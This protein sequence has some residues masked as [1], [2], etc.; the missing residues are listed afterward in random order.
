LHSRIQSTVRPNLVLG[1]CCLSLLVVGMD[2]TIVNV[3][4]PAIRRDFHAEVSGLQ[5]LMDAYTLVVASLLMLGG[6]TADRLGRRRTF[7]AGMALF[8]FASLL[9]SLAPSIGLLI[10]F[11]ALQGVGAS[12]L[13]PVAM[14]IITNTFEEPKAR[15]K[16]IGVWGAVAGLSLAVGPLL[17][18]ALTQFV[19][20][21]SIFW[22]NLPIGI[23]A[24]VLA[25]R[26]VPESKAAKPR[27][28]DP[29]GQFL[30]FVGLASLI[31]AIIEGP[32]SGWNSGR[33]EVAF[34]VSAVAVVT[35]VFYERRCTEPLLDL[36]FFGSLPFSS[37]TLI[38]VCAFSAFAA[39][40]L[41]NALYLQQV[42]G[43][44]P[45]IAGLCTL[46]VALMTILCA[47]ISGRLVGVYGTRPSLLLAGLATLISSLLLTRLTTD[48][49]IPALLLAYVVYGA[50]FAIVNIPITHTAVSGM[51]RSQAGVA[52]A[53]ASTSRQV[54]ASL[55]VAVA[56]TIIGI[57]QA[58]G[59]NFAQATHPVWWIMAVCG[60]TISL[61]G[62]V[63]NTPWAKETAQ[64]VAHLLTEP[65]DSRSTSDRNQNDAPL[66]GK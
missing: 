27:A 45:F 15:A 14:S 12:M 7:Q 9:C 51:P 25:A 63:T 59:L 39:F 17:G 44:S 19:G 11:R 16:A 18:G 48:T 43:F 49:P 46:P 31:Y 52:A 40:L 24:M 41:L 23:A 6:S 26:F 10:A 4:L 1:I 13:N 33:I 21:R 35:L 53:I 65:A 58:H 57:G 50:G 38:A 36:R 30:V 61:L 2:V 29:I 54:G 34:A 8:T 20:W 47:P 62:W 22:I 56:G 3:A 28:V 60:T 55:G 37:A 32:H 66:I 5:W 64:R 42:R